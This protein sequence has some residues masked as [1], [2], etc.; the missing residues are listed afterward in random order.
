MPQQVRGQGNMRMPT[1]SESKLIG[2]MR[3]APRCHGAVQCE[4]ERQPWV[5]RASRAIG[6]RNSRAD[7]GS[8]G[9]PGCSAEPFG[10]RRPDRYM[11]LCHLQ[12]CRQQ[13]GPLAKT[14]AEAGEAPPREGQEEACLCDRSPRPQSLHPLTPRRPTATGGPTVVAG[15]GFAR[16]C[17]KPP[18]GKA[19]SKANWQKL[20]VQFLEPVG[21]SAPR[22]QPALHPGGAL[23][24]GS[25]AAKTGAA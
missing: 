14:D 23:F 19:A 2:A 12:E 5:G 21:A 15:R 16:S 11:L 6:A 8:Q 24:A 13:S 4:R 18:C 20:G 22:R 10:Q 25:G 1:P 17:T 7:Q 3:G 9:C